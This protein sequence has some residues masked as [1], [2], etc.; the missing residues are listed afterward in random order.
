[1][2]ASQIAAPITTQSMGVY[3]MSV[4]DKHV[5]LP[6]EKDIYQPGSKTPDKW[7]GTKTIFLRMS[8]RRIDLMHEKSGDVVTFKVTKSGSRI[9]VTRSTTMDKAKAVNKGPLGPDMIEVGGK[10]ESYTVDRALACIVRMTGKTLD[11]V[12]PLFAL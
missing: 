8:T 12:S 1:M 4:D 9:S 3:T 10:P 2:N 6:V 5:K 11:E 7:L